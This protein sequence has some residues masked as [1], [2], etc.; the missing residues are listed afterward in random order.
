MELSA[1]GGSDEEQV[2][3]LLLD[4]SG[5]AC[6]FKSVVTQYLEMTFVASLKLFNF[7]VI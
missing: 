6:Y 7:Q 3:H 2:V 5:Q 1:L 4:Q